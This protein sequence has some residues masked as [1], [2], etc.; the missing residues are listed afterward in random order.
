MHA[1]FA[2]F[3]DVVNYFKIAHEV[4]KSRVNIYALNRTGSPFFV[5]VGKAFAI[6]GRIPSM[7]SKRK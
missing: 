2:I 1:N 6:D 7:K 5:S 3:N 4:E